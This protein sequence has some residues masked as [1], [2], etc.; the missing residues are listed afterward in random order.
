MGESKRI[1]H[2]IALTRD[3]INA[4]SQRKEGCAIADLDFKAAFD[5]LCMD[6]VFEVLRK[7]SLQHEA[8]DRLKR[9]YNNSIT[10]PIVYNVPGKRF[11]NTRLTLQQG[12]CPT[13]TWFGY[14]IDPLLVYLDKKLNVILIHSLPVLGPSMK[15]EPKRLNS[16]EQR[17]S[18]VGYC[19][20]L[21]PAIYN[22][23]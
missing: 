21:K 13:S 14:G 5:F 19:N 6:W 8:I 23:Q 18:V 20:D 12:D 2:A 3:T 4:A 22:L 7:K 15:K 9:Y 10:I 17:Y 1:N 16:L 11:T